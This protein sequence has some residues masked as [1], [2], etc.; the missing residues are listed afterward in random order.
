MACMHSGTPTVDVRSAMATIHR[1]LYPALCKEYDWPPEVAGDY[2]VDFVVKGIVRGVR[3]HTVRITSLQ[4][5]SSDK[6]ATAQHGAGSTGSVHKERTT[7]E[8]RVS[9][10]P[11]S[12]P[13]TPTTYCVRSVLRVRCGAVDASGRSLQIEVLESKHAVLPQS[14]EELAERAASLQLDGSSVATSRR[15]CPRLCRADQCF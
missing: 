5:A 10:I 12:T 3:D 11:G 6:F 14:F 8:S 1:P 13:S 2:S 7:R 15:L 9:C 4:S